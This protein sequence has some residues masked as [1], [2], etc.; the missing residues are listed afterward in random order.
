ME[1]NNK[2]L[3]YL[4]EKTYFLHD[5]NFENITIGYKK[6]LETIPNNY[7]KD[8]IDITLI[9]NLTDNSDNI[10][11][12]KTVKIIFYDVSE[13]NFTTKD[14]SNWIFTESK[15]EQNSDKNMFFIDNILRIIYKSCT[16][17]IL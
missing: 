7:P 12:K 1:E 3:K 9:I 14:T 16:W 17:K 2:S 15:I 4:L 11:D 6:Y 5:C 13:Y 8:N 10:F